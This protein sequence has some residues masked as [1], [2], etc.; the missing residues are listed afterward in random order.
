MSSK[1]IYSIAI[2]SSKLSLGHISIEGTG[3]IDCPGNIG[4]GSAISLTILD[5]LSPILIIKL[6]A[7]S[8]A[9]TYKERAVKIIRTFFINCIMLI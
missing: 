3:S 1:K 5:L 6:Q 4:I 8:A 9:D 2:S 7:A